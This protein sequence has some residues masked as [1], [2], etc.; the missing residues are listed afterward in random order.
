MVKLSNKLDLIKQ[1]YINY[2]TST[3]ANIIFLI[4]LGVYLLFYLT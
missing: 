3:I 2:Y 1:V 4:V